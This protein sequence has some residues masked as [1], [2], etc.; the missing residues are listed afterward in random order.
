MSLFLDVCEFEY[1]L[2]FLGSLLSPSPHPEPVQHAELL[3][4][5]YH[6][7]PGATSLEWPT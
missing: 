4:R 5:G 6:R 1:K 2:V 7:E 3:G